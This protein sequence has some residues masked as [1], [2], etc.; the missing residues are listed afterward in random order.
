MLPDVLSLVE[1]NQEADDADADR[2][3]ACL[4]RAAENDYILVF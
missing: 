3:R 2:W 4:L 1:L